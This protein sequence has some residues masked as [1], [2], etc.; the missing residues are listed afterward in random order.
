MVSLR[1]VGEF[2]GLLTFRQE[3]REEDVGRVW[4]WC[5]VQITSV[6]DSYQRKPHEPLDTNTYVAVEPGSKMGI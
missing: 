3:H 1:G 6:A 2:A 4:L 5:R